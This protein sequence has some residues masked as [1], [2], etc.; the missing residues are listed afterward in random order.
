MCWHKKD[1]HLFL[2]NCDNVHLDVVG[3][4]VDV[5]LLS[6]VRTL[7]DNKPLLRPLQLV[8]ETDGDDLKF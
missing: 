2:W 5:I 8:A 7:V 1:K 3:A 4:D 6:P